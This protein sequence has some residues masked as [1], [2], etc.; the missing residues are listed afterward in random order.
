MNH[1]DKSS[2]QL[3]VELAELQ[4]RVA[5]LEAQRARS[6]QREATRQA[7]DASFRAHVD[8]AADSL[9]LYDFA[10]RLLDANTQACVS[11]GYSREELL[12]LSLFDV[13]TEFD[14]ARAQD[15]ASRIAPGEVVTV[16]GRQRRKDGSTFPV[17]VRVSRLDVKGEQYFLALAR[18]ITEHTRSEASVQAREERLRLAMEFTNEGVWDLDLVTGKVVSNDRWLAL[19]GHATEKALA[20]FAQ[21]ESMLH[22]DDAANAMRAMRN[23]LAGLTPEFHSEHR[24][25]T[26]SGEVRWHLNVGKVVARDAGRRPLRMVGTTSDISQ[27]KRAEEALRVSERK[28]KTLTENM[29]DV[30]S[31]IDADTLRFRYVSPSVLALRGYAPEEIIGQPMDAALTEENR[32]RFRSFV[33]ERTAAFRT[34]ALSTDSYYTTQIEQRRKDGSTVPTEIIWHFLRNPVTDA[35]EIHGV[36]R[37]ITARKQAE[38][39]LRE[40]WQRLRLAADLADIGVWRWNLPD[41]TLEWDERLF[42]WFEVPEAVRQSGLHY[43]YWRE[44]VHPDDIRR[45][46]E[47]LELSRLNKSPGDLVYRF[48]RSD[49]GVRY[50]HAA[51]VVELDEHGEALR[52]LGVCR[53]VTPQRELEESLRAARQAAELANVA[54]GDFLANMSH[55]IRTPMNGVIGMTELLL[56]TELNSQQRRFAETIRTSGDSLL[57][58]I[59]DILDFSKIEAGRLELET[60]EFDL[61]TVL[62]ELA[63]PLALRA[64]DKGIELIC[65]ASPGVPSRLLG[66]PGRLRQILTNL[67]SNAV[68]FTEH[69]EISIRASLVSETEAS[70]MVRFVIRDTGIGITPEQRQRLFQKFTQADASTTRRF[71]GTGLG[72]A[73][74]RQLAELMGGE[75]G[76]TSEAGVGSE[77]WFTARL[78]KAAQQQVPAEPPD[79]L[80]GMHVLVVDDNATNR[81]ILRTQLAAWGIEAEAVGD[82][83]AALRSLARARDDHCPF[84]AALIDMR[85]PGMDGNSL[86]QAVREDASFAATR[87]VLLTSLGRQGGIADLAQRGFAACL[88]KPIRQADLLDCLCRVLA[89]RFAVQHTVVRAERDAIPPLRR[90]SAKVLVAEDNIVNQEVALA[91]LRKLGLQANAVENG[92]EAIETLRGERYDLVLMDVEMPEID[93][94]EATRRIRDPQS[95][96]RNHQIPIIAMTAAAMQGDRE[97]CLEA[98]M[99][100]YVTKPVSPK[101]LVEALNAWLP[102]ETGSTQGTRALS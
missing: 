102:E 18:D 82:G 85:M 98:G 54:K 70:V 87:L 73:I 4:R 67:A 26:K 49:G 56:D 89:G 13:E 77:F 99:N 76:M 37:D 47:T 8:Q 75:I 45:S 80:R 83:P 95:A 36:T 32:S 24:I 93:G 46:E 62:D 19:H 81:E 7:S 27:R 58:L 14:Q 15:V 88:T 92:E 78:G 48:L 79:S 9:L 86:A 39:Q 3:L 35:V 64:H 84:R 101:A 12:R 51:W 16:T 42:A 91:I 57:T 72:L 29:K 23:Y 5:E 59:N 53:D 1:Q 74:A 60:L 52:M 21:W 6:Q 94:L 55:E 69:G 31:T 34:G 40:A 66:D 22:P 100:A 28:Y 50:I 71:G 68:K 65:A 96:V 61:H 30:V 25:I 41:G 44:R 38:L 97:R 11:L 20:D 33:T 90:T 10:G 63:A 43:G 2:E 17:E